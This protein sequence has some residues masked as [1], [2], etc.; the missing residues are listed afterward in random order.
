MTEKTTAEKY[1]DFYKTE[2]GMKILEQESKYIVSKLKNC[3]KVLSIGCG[4]AFIEA[5]A[6]E[7]N[8]KLSIIGLDSS[9]EMLKFAPI[10]VYKILGDAEKLGVRAQTVDAVLYITALEFIENYKKAVLEAVR[11]L[12]AKGKL[13]ALILNPNSDYFKQGYAKNGYLQ[14]HIK[15]LNIERLEEFVAHYFSINTEY[16]LGI[17]N[18]TVFETTD[19]K[20]AGLY[21]INGI[22]KVKRSAK[23]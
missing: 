3:K 2:L 5:R 4:P 13:L 10:S 14:R 9:K 6:A 22:K 17:K 15:H 20:L 1:S 21:V 18:S 7:L 11:V 23:V 16:F 19:P 8:P 12:K